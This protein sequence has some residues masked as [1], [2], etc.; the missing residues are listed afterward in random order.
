MLFKVLTKQVYL[1]PLSG[2]SR[3]YVTRGNDS[4]IAFWEK[5]KSII[6]IKMINMKKS[7]QLMVFSDAGLLPV[8]R[9]GNGTNSAQKGPPCW[10]TIPIFNQSTW[11]ARLLVDAREGWDATLPLTWTLALPRSPHLS[12]RWLQLLSAR[13]PFVGCSPVHIYSYL[14]GFVLT[15]L[16]LSS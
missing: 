13:S 4:F 14:F 11:M 8:S 10:C 3:S 5:M 15:H 9:Q 6:C 16:R 2:C 7:I 12:A 1:I